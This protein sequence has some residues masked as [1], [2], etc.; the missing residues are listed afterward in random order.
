MPRE[1]QTLFLRLNYL[2]SH[3][4]ATAD[5]VDTYIRYF[6]ARL[7]NPNKAARLEGRES[8][9]RA[10]TL[11]HFFEEI[12]QIDPGGSEDDHKDIDLWVYFHILRYS[13]ER[14]LEEVDDRIPVQVKSSSDGVDKAMRHMEAHA[15][16]RFVIDVGF[17]RE[18]EEILAEIQD[19]FAGEIGISLTR[20]Q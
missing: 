14:G 1:I 8:E 2:A 9:G 18:D 6:K 19:R 7:E 4:R 13:D 10:I 15:D 11:F 3:P 12:Y 16:Y 17:E 5:Q 20:T